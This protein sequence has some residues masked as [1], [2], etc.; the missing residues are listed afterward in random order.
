M[1]ECATDRQTDRQTW[2]THMTSEYLKTIPEFHV[3]ILS[4]QVRPFQHIVGNNFCATVLPHAENK[5][6][7]LKT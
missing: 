1:P 7:Q 2:P 3:Q 4:G 5:G 6:L